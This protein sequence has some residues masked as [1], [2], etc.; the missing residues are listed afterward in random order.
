[1]M[2]AVF[3]Y[4]EDFAF[5]STGTLIIFSRNSKPAVECFMGL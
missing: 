2:P 4:P 3:I 5:H 1:M